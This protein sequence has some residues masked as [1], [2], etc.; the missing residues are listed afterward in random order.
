DHGGAHGVHGVVAHFEY[1]FV[2]H[3]HQHVHVV[4]TVDPGGHGDHRALDDVGGAALH[5]RIHR[6][7]FGALAQAVI[8]RVEVF[9][10]Q[11]AAEDGFHVAIAMGFLAGGVH[12]AAHAGIAGEITSDVIA[13]F[14]T[15]HTQRAGQTERAHAVHQAEVDCLGRAP[16][17]GGHLL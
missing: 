16:L 5:R 1:Q 8:A 3:L 11:P 13:G 2:V 17:I 14:A 7:A 12:V 10:I 9:Q 15:I 4:A 6:G